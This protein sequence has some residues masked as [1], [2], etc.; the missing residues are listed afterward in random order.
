MLLTLLL[1]GYIPPSDEFFYFL[2][3]LLGL[4]VVL[5]LWLLVLGVRQIRRDSTQMRGSTTGLLLVDELI[6]SISC[7]GSI[8]GQWQRQQWW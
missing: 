2:F 1:S 3:F 6:L 5:G 4:F 8:G 7:L